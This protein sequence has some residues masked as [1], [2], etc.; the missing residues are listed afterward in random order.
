MSQKMM[1]FDGPLVRFTE[2]AFNLIFLNLLTILC[3]IPVVTFGASF[4]AMNTVVI[5]MSRDEEGYVAKEF[6]KAFKANLKIGIKTSVAILLFLA[7]VGADFYAISLLDVWFADV[8]KVLLLFF[9]IMFLIAVT[10]LFP[11]MSKF[12]AGFV[13][14]VKNSFKFA[15]SHPLK[16]FLL[17]IINIVLWV[18]VYFLIFLAPLLF[19]YGF[20][21][22]GYIGTSVYRKDFEKMEEDYY[23]RQDV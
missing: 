19:M 11:I 18:I 12:E 22:P 15:V 14:T 9:G 13:D 10:F 16:T 17:F 3:C 23:A 6:F 21:L 2:K 5:K 1:D 8:A 20:S 4:A 7:F